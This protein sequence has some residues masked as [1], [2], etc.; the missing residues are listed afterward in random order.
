MPESEAG[1]RARVRQAGAIVIRS[2]FLIRV[3][4]TKTE[5]GRHLFIVAGMGWVALAV[6]A[7]LAWVLA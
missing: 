7:A 1:Q 5:H 6:A 3:S 2:A 4:I